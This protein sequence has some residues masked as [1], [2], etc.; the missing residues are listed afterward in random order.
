VE[1]PAD[2]GA[3]PSSPVDPP[4]VAIV[5]AVAGAGNPSHA[6]IEVRSLVNQASTDAEVVALW[7]HG[8]SPHTQRGYRSAVERFA[9]FVGKPLH[10]VTVRDL[11]AFADSLR[12]LSPSS[13]KTIIA[14]V[15]SLFSYAHRR[16]GYLGY[17]VGAPIEPPKVKETVAG[18][19]LSESEVHRMLAHA[20]G[21][22]AVLLRLLYSAGVRVSEVCGVSW[23][24][25]AARGDAGQVTVFGKGG[26]TRT[27][28]LS[29]E[30][31]RELAKLRASMEPSECA[32]HEPVFR[33]GRT[34]ARGTYHLSAVHVWRIIRAA[35]RRAGID[36][37][38]SP[39]WFR[40]SHASHALERGAAIHLVQQ[41]LGHS[42]V[43]TTSVYL[44]ARPSDSSALYLGV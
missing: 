8:R 26:K 43:A 12:D 30:T 28:L 42:S 33:S 2:G 38:V 18:R 17:N 3:L 16:V 31:W 34:N 15:R 7:L 6:P 5:G 23:C 29:A 32:P 19:I 25:V 40:H 35:A 14:A 27:V 20:E 9:L 1:L 39:H 37:G 21:R 13:Q 24:D 41:T 44:H 11:Q 10:A 4:G 36:A 22:D